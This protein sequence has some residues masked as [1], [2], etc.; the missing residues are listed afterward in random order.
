MSYDHD[1]QELELFVENDADIYRRLRRPAYA[2]LTEAKARGT[3]DRDR[4][5]ALFR[6]M[7]DEGVRKWQREVGPKTFIPSVRKEVARNM[8]SY[9]ETEHKLGNFDD[10]LPA[11]LQP[12]KKSPAELQRDIDNVI[13]K[14]KRSKSR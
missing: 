11:S 9:F 2:K 1:V 10:L 6:A 5:I 3:Y 4:A 12:R 7:A 13:G 8:L 14:T